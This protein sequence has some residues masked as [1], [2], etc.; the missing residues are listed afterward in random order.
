MK[1]LICTRCGESFKELEVENI[2]TECKS[3]VLKQTPGFIY[4]GGT[5]GR[6]PPEEDNHSESREQEH[7]DFEDRMN[8]HFDLSL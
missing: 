4:G 3:I 7:Q 1:D 6:F 2:C 5:S 8:D